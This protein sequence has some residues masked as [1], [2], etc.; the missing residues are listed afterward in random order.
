MTT[1]ELRITPSL[2]KG[3]DGF[4][5]LEVRLCEA[6]KAEDDMG[7]KRQISTEEARSVGTRLGL[8]WAQIDLT[9]D[10]S[11]DGNGHEKYGRK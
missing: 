6:L 3:R 11:S 4:Y 9:V 1:R 7:S 2:T 5:A 8:D 10:V